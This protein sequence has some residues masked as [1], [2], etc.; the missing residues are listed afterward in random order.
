MRQVSIELPVPGGCSGRTQ[1]GSVAFASVASRKPNPRMAAVIARIVKC[2]Q[3]AAA[4]EFSLCG[5]RSRAPSEPWTEGVAEGAIGS[6]FVALWY[7]ST[8]HDWALISA[9]RVP[10]IAVI[11]HGVTSV[12]PS[13]LSLNADRT[14]I[15][16]ITDRLNNSEGPKRFS[17]LGSI[18]GTQKGRNQNYQK[19]SVASERTPAYHANLTRTARSAG[20]PE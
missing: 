2:H 14:Q 8:R 4:S 9:V 5:T 7:Y 19:G 17:E 6:S 10:R 3:L 1:C 18:V 13:T 12:G 15:L 20:K 16:T 11:S